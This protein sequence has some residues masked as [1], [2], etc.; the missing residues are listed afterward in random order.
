MS[1]V[2][3]RPTNGVSY[4]V[5]YTVTSGDASAK[6]ITFDFRKQNDA[7]YRFDL[8]AQIDILN[9]SGLLQV[10][11]DLGWGYPAKGVVA[12][13][14]TLLTGTVIQLLAQNAGAVSG[15]YIV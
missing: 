6:L 12:V 4:G 13:S 15:T 3:C 2:Y 7:N 11:A 14:G 9:A 1:T 8:V 5:R 10:P